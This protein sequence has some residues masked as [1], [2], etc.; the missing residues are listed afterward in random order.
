[1]NKLAR[2][3]IEGCAHGQSE[4]PWSGFSRETW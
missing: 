3:V 2:N 1:M 4:M